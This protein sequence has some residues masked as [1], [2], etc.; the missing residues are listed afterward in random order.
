[1]SKRTNTRKLSLPNCGSWPI[2]STRKVG[3]GAAQARRLLTAVEINDRIGADRPKPE[4]HCA[5]FSARKR[6]LEGPLR[7]GH[8]DTGL[9]TTR[10][11]GRATRLLCQPMARGQRVGCVVIGR[12]RPRDTYRVWP[13]AGCGSPTD[14]EIK[15][16]GIQ[17]AKEFCAADGKHAVITVEQTTG[18]LVL[19]LQTAEVQF[20]C[21][22]RPAAQ[23]DKSAKP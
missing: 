8:R 21:D 12:F 19:G 6:R 10:H 23:A 9:G 11:G 13:E 2:A 17:R 3:F 14:A 15:A 4:V 1:M 7:S 20:Y 18:W 5:E 16:C 22:A